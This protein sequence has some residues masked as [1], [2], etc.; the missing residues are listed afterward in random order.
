MIL[1][2]SLPW[3]KEAAG[4]GHSNWGPGGANGFWQ[5]IPSDPIPTQSASEVGGV[6]PH[7]SCGRPR[8]RLGLV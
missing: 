2:E 4:P 7:E 8:S 3:G 1:A 6:S 5:A